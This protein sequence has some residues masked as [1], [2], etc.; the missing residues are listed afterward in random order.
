MNDPGSAILAPPPRYLL[1]SDSSDEEGQGEYAASSSRR[2]TQIRTAPQ[3]KLD[4]GSKSAP[5]GIHDVVIGIGLTGR[6][7]KR[8][9]CGKGEAVL[10]VLVDEEEVGSGWIVDESFLLV[11]EDHEGEVAWKVAEKVMESLKDVKW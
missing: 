6:Y 11:L 5:S 10:R 8:K 4:Y 3:V 9:S 7:L 2:I 1:E